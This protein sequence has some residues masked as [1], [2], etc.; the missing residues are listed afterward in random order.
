[1]YFFS[2]GKEVRQGIPA[3]ENDLHKALKIWTSVSNYFLFL[4]RFL[5]V[6]TKLNSMESNSQ[7][8]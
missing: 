4:Q 7:H 3:K 1:M 8:S 2:V 6:E 5:V